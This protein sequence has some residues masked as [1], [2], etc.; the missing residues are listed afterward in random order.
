MPLSGGP[1]STLAATEVKGYASVILGDSK[2]TVLVEREDQ[3]IY[4]YMYISFI[5]RLLV[6]NIIF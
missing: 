2:V 4:I 5:R 3:Y 1:L 6:G